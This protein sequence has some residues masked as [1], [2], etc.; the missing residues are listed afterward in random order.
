MDR[1]EKIA[2]E[3]TMM[4]QPEAVACILAVEVAE[5]GLILLE[6]I[7]RYRTWRTT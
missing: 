6:L 7:M 5:Y 1:D 4:S 2:A 3:G